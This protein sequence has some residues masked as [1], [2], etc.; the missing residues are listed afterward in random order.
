MA[1]AEYNRLKKDRPSS[2]TCYRLKLL[3]EDSREMRLPHNTQLREQPV[4]TRGTPPN[5]H[6]SGCRRCGG[7]CRLGSPEGCFHRKSKPGYWRIAEVAG[8]VRSRSLKDRVFLPVD[9][10]VANVQNCPAVILSLAGISPT[11]S[12]S[13]YCR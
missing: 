2:A 3:S 10:A 6:P 1:N 13:R 4:S 7:R 12:K 5:F 9:I 8:T 11:Q